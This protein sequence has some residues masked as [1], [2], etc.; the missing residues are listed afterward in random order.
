MFDVVY[1][2]RLVQYANRYRKR[3][4]EVHM[5]LTIAESKFLAGDYKRTIL[6]AE[7]VLEEFDPAAIERIKEQC[8]RHSNNGQ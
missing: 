1:A 6:L 3:D 2:E 8:A 5:S 4:N 7:R